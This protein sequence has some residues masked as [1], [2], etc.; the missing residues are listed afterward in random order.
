VLLAAWLVAGWLTGGGDV[1]PPVRQMKARPLAVKMPEKIV[2]VPLFGKRT[3]IPSVPEF[4]PV[5]AVP[6]RLN[7]RLLGTVLAGERSLAIIQVN[8]GKENV[9]VLGGN[10]Q[11]GVV[12]KQ[13][14][15]NAII[16]SHRGRMERVMMLRGALAAFTVNDVPVVSHRHQFTRAVIQQ[17]MSDLPKLLTGALAVPHQMDGH[18][19][20]FLIQ[21]IV[22]GSLYEQAGLKNGDVIHKVNGQEITMQKQ[23]IALFKTLQNAQSIDLDI[24]RSGVLQRLHF[25]I[26]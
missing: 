5:E 23:G 3:R 1:S 18:P 13:V 16:V 2:A 22:P 11:Q 21:H 17:Q 7:I 4:R 8:R 19:D 9:I 10:I 26:N 20:G 6:T 14:E 25:D 15:E 24:T 12:L